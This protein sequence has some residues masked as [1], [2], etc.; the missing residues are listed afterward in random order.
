M[1]FLI[2]ENFYHSSIKKSKNDFLKSFLNILI[3]YF[4]SFCILF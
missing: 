2:V 4:I 1:I 3:L